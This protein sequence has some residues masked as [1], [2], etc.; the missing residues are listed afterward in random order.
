MNFMVTISQNIADFIGIDSKIISMLIITL[1][2]IL[3][4]KLLTSIICKLI[5][6]IQK[7]NRLEFML[8]KKI[9]ILSNFIMILILLN[10]WHA[11]ITDFITFISFFSAGVAIA[12]RD[13]IFNFIC[14]IYIKTNKPFH[15]EDRISVG[16]HFGDVIDIR[17]FSFSLLEV[18]NKELNG[19]S[20]GIIIHCPNSMI[21][22]QPL[23]N[24]TLGFKYIWN[25]L[26][27]SIPLTANIKK[28]KS[29]IYRILNQNEVLKRIPKKMENAV[30]DA[31]SNYRIYYNKL[32]PIIYTKLDQ[33]HIRL[34]VRYLVH[35]KKARYVED[36]I[37]N[38]IIESYKKGEIEL[39]TRND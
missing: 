3:V 7:D 25:E 23:R 10:I 6:K 14:G 21:F 39:Y 30:N 35:P 24:F 12:L 38:S 15:L 18:S 29:I 34:Q 4:I 17:T 5:I 9:K 26:E 27:L 28:I 8:I 22:T 11:Y 1:F 37:W 16:D 32:D 33:D 31:S 2:A 13:I 36:M 20:T 19:Q